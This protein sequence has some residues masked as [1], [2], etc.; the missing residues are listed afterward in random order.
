[1]EI[2]ANLSRADIAEITPAFAVVLPSNRELKD[3]KL[4]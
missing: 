1:M 3:S 4:K 2:V